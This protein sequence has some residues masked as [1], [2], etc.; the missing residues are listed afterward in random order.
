MR[1]AAL[2]SI[3]MALERSVGRLCATGFH[4]APPSVLF[5]TPAVK[6]PAYRIDGLV[7]STAMAPSLPTA[8]SAPELVM[9]R[10][11]I[12]YH[13]PAAGVA[14]STEDDVQL[15]PSSAST[16]VLKRSVVIENDKLVPVGAKG[17]VIQTLSTAPSAGVSTSN[18]TPA[19]IKRVRK[20]VVTGVRPLFTMRNVIATRLATAG[21]GRAMCTETS[22]T[23]RSRPATGGGSTALCF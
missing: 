16:T 18:V 4:V 8:S 3:V 15:L 11:P 9:R 14:T 22:S 10:G 5:H 20:L 21:S 7:G 17:R 12:A 19:T 13:W 6:P 1:E 2:G 23:R